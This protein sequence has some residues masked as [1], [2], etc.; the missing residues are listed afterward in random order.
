MDRQ[1]NVRTKTPFREAQAASSTSSRITIIPVIGLILLFMLSVARPGLAA[2]AYRFDLKWGTAGSGDG[3]FNEPTG[4]AVSA[5]GNVYVSDKGNTRVQKFSTDGTFIGKWGSGGTAD[6]QFKEPYGILVDA[7]GNVFVADISLNDSNGRRIQKF[8]ASGTFI[9]KWI[10]YGSTYGTGGPPQP[11]SMYD[12]G[13]DS[14]GYFYIAANCG[15]RCLFIYKL[16]A[17]GSTIDAF[18]RD[19][20]EYGS[21]D[22]ALGMPTGIAV[23]GT[24][25]YVA[26]HSNFV[27]K[28]DTSGTFIKKWGS[29]GTGDGQFDSPQGVAVD[30]Q[31]NVYVADTKNH[32]VQKFSADGTFITKWG[33]YGS[34]DGQFNEPYYIDVDAAGNVYVTDKNNH[35]VQKFR[36]AVVGN[37]PPQFSCP[38]VQNMDEQDDISTLREL[39]NSIITSPSGALL[40]TLYYRD[41]GEISSIIAG[42]PALQEKFKHLVSENIGTAEELLAAG[43]VMIAAEKVDAIVAAL[44]EIQAAAGPKLRSDIDLVIMGL[45]HGYLLEGLGIKIGE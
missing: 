36:R 28:S 45:T 29:Y 43:E 37:G 38:F 10:I 19:M 17:N 27:H 4:I 7:S 25:L 41:A 23:F 30:A 33:S 34:G 9:T 32:R 22:Y 12:L 11:I 3:Q 20:P 39:R 2:E 13:I 15:Y 6:G 21:G 16:D 42:N 5:A 24:Y 8:D 14:A 35:R 40:A 31:G 1:Q 44:H 18:D 26:D